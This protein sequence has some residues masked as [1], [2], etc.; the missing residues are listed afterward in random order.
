MLLYFWNYR[1]KRHSSDEAKNLEQYENHQWPGM[2][3]EFFLIKKRLKE[4]GLDKKPDEPI[5]VWIN[6]IHTLEP[7]LSKLPSLDA[8]VTLHYRY[9]FYARDLKLNEREE[10]SKQ[11]REWL[12]SYSIAAKNKL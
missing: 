7:A 12:D 11:V 3:S 6:R 10:L 8:L 9:R 5:S 2:D 1:R 4:K